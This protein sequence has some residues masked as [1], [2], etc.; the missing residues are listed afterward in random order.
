MGPFAEAS[1]SSW[2][3]RCSTRAPKLNSSPRRSPQLSDTLRNRPLFGKPSPCLEAYLLKIGFLSAKVAL[4]FRKTSKTGAFPR[5]TPPL[6]AESEIGPLSRR[7]GLISGLDCNPFSSREVRFIL[8]QASPL[9]TGVRDE[10]GSCVSCPQHR[11]F[12][13]LHPVRNTASVDMFRFD[14]PARVVSQNMRCF[15]TC[16]PTRKHFRLSCCSD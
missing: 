4:V 3:W 2:G 7:L 11:S 13:R 12:L 10:G 14:A 6:P 5:G 16:L 9:S 8:A 15:D 1:F